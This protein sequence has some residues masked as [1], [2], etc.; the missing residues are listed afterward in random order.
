MLLLTPA[1]V[2]GDKLLRGG[3]SG[4]GKEPEA[5]SAVFPLY[6]DVYPHGCVPPFL[7]FPL[8]VSVPMEPSVSAHSASLDSK[9]HEELIN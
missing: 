5:S 6:G 7:L 1:A 2:R 4:A 3:P 9:S 8:S